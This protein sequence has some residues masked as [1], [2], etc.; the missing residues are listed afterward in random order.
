MIPP[1]HLPE[2]DPDDS[3]PGSPMPDVALPKIYIIDDDEA[4]RFAISMLVGTFG[5]EAQCFASTEE[6]LQFPCPEGERCCLVLDLNMPGM[7]GADLLDNLNAAGRW[8]P[9]IV[10]T[11]FPDGPLAGRARRAGARA[12]LRKPFSDQHLLDHIR[13]ALDLGEP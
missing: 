10:V 12:V 5:W 8:L 4:V 3:T 7:N 6:F 9:V 1:V 2:P 13:R 11:S